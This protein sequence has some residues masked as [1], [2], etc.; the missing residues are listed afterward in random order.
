MAP[1]LASLVVE[2]KEKLAICPV[3]V[4]REHLERPQPLPCGCND[5]LSL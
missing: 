5:Y 3:R 4:I 2:D 1:A